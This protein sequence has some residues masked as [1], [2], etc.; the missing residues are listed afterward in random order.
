MRSSDLI[1]L[2]IAA[3]AA[4]FIVSRSNAAKAATTAP[5]STTMTSESLAWYLNDIY[6]KLGSQAI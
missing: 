3:G 1:I 2:A 4:W 5:T 6:S